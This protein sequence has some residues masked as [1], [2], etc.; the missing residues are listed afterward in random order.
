MRRRSFLAATAVGATVGLSGCLDGEVVMDVNE[1]PTIPAYQG[2]TKEIDEVDG[3]GEVAYTVRSEDDR[4]EIFYFRDD[5]AF[6]TYQ[7]TTLGGDEIPDDP[8][9]GYEPLR[10]IA[11]E[12][13]ERGVYEAVMPAD[14]S[15]YSVDIEGSHYFVVDNS[16]YGEVDVEDRTA[17]LPVFVSLEVVEDRF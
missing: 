6:A 5:E 1:S 7:Q 3:S 8:P 10:A 17:D 15:R 2:W 14:G 13:Q 11:V 4:F 12:N 16:N 9:L